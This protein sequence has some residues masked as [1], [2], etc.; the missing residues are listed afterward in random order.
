MQAH[1]IVLNGLFKYQSINFQCIFVVKVQ[2]LAQG[3][4]SLAGC[5]CKGDS[6]ENLE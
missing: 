3:G 2:L 5:D 1:H 4:V 6:T